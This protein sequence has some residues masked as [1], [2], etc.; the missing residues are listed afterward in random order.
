MRVK[1]WAEVPRVGIPY[2]CPA[3]RLDVAENPATAVARAAATA[4]I[5]CVRR[6][7]ISASGRPPAALVI[8][9]AADATAESWLSTDRMR[10]SSTTAS[11]N[12]PSTVRT[13]DPGK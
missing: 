1:E 9:E 13:G 3:A 4:E 2:A 12:D 11:P 8:R 7:P 6:D 5:S 10:V